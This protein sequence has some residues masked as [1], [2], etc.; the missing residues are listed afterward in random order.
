MYESGQ[1]PVLA[2]IDPNGVVIKETIHTHIPYV[3]EKT[4]K[5]KMPRLW[6]GVKSA[7]SNERITQIHDGY[8]YLDDGFTIR[9]T[10]KKTSRQKTIMRVHVVRK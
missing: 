10:Y 9:R 3:N 8:A 2:Y 6:G 7:Y 4:H 1:Y 5:H